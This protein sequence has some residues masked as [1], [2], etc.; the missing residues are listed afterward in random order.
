MVVAFRPGVLATVVG[1]LATRRRARRRRMRRRS[2]SSGVRSS[3]RSRG[4]EQLHVRRT[5]RPTSI[6]PLSSSTPSGHGGPVVMVR[7]S[8]NSKARRLQHPDRS[9]WAVACSGL[10]QG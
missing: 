3:W 6:S 4:L 8:Q 7:N 10:V 9:R 1:C 5:V 2:S